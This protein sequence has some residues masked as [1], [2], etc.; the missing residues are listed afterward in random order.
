MQARLATLRLDFMRISTTPAVYVAGSV[1]LDIVLCGLSHEPRLGE[2]QWVSGGALMAGGAANQ[3]VACTRLGLD[4]ELLTYVGTDE[5]G[6]LV[7]RM[8]DRDEVGL[9]YATP[10]ERQNMTVALSWSGD[11]ALVTHGVDAAPLPSDEMPAPAILMASLP[12]LAAA[13]D[14]VDRWREAGT[15]VIAD[16]AWDPTEEWKLTDLDALRPSDIFTPNC[17]EAKR[18]ARTDSRREAAR[19][20]ADRV[21]AV[22]VTCGSSGT[23]VGRSSGVVHHPALDVDCIDSTGA[24]DAFTAGVAAG[25]VAGFDIDDAVRLGQAAGGWTVQRVGG[26]AVAP[27]VSDLA[28]WAQ[29][30]PTVAEYVGEFVRRFTADGLLSAGQSH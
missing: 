22:T 13:A 18:Y 15:V 29:D 11:R 28:R 20:L 27:R 5:A 8:L 24:G 30:D 2:E 3:A 26:S 17:A 9:T 14:Q 6:G 10:T 25:L 1:F 19:I 7:R 12:Y 4:V 23:L 16:T 21:A